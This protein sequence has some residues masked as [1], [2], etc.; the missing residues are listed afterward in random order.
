MG[1]ID[2][3]N[4]MV[5]AVVGSEMVHSRPG[6]APADQYVRHERAIYNTVPALV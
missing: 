1:T 3:I 5:D 6:I 4:R 2:E